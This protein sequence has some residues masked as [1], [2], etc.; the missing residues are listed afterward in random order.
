MDMNDQLTKAWYKQFWPWFLIALPGSVVIASVAT[1]IIATRNPDSIVVDDYYKAGLAIN[2]NLSRE[3][4]ASHLGIQS[5]LTINDKQQATIT[6]TAKK[7]AIPAELTLKFMHPTLADRDQV[8]LLSRIDSVTFSGNIEPLSSG[9]WN[10]A[11][12]SA[13]PSWRIQE[14]IDIDHNKTVYTIR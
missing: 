1:I 12:E 7:G 4:L 5:R 6:L 3:Q 14:R 2:R 11:I 9:T 10:I 8:I 13:E